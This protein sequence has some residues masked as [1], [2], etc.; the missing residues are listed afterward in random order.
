MKIACSFSYM[1]PTTE[2]VLETVRKA[3]VKERSIRSTLARICG[4]SP[5]AVRDWQEGRTQNIKH[6][7]LVAISRHYRVSIDWLLTGKDPYD[8]Q[9]RDDV[10]EAFSI[11]E[12]KNALSELSVDGL[13]EAL[14]PWI[15]SLPIE[16]RAK[17]ARAALGRE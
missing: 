9:L 15:E 5:Q 1:N 7:H 13:I 16:D 4:I 17:L 12:M 10:Q 14:T 11:V 2:R 3:G 8:A 6:E